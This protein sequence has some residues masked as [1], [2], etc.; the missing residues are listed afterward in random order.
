MRVFRRTTDELSSLYK[1]G[2][3]GHY[4]EAQEIEPQ[5]RTNQL[6]LPRRHRL[7]PVQSLSNSVFMGKSV[8]RRAS[9]TAASAA[10]GGKR[11]VSSKYNTFRSLSVIAVFR[12]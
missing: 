6:K 5:Q 10:F 1:P 3:D 12:Q 11:T 2:S 4:A 9:K 8:T 7:T